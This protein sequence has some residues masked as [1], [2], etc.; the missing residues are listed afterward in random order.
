M[1][2]FCALVQ[3]CGLARRP[4]FTVACLCGSERS[5]LLLLSEAGLEVCPLMSG[6]WR[7]QVGLLCVDSV[8]VDKIGDRSRPGSPP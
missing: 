4:A 7:Q 6:T 3:G 8:F 2:D 1:L 5:E